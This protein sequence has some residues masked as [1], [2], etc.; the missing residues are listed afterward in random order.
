[1]A[2]KFHAM[3]P[4]DYAKLGSFVKSGAGGDSFVSLDSYSYGGMDLSDVEQTLAGMHKRQ[5]IRL[6]TPTFNYVLARSQ[7]SLLAKLLG[8]SHNTWKGIVAVDLIYDLDSNE[9]V[10]VDEAPQDG[11]YL[12]GAE[13]AERFISDL[14]VEEAKL[15]CI[16]GAIAD[17]MR[18]GA[19]VSSIFKINRESKGAH[20]TCDY[21][22]EYTKEDLEKYYKRGHDPERFL[23][24]FT[25]KLFAN[26]D[27]RF[28]YLMNMNQDKSGL[29]GMLNYYLSVVPEEMRP[30]IDRGEHKLTARYAKVLKADFEYKAIKGEH[31]NPKDI[32]AKYLVMDSSV[33]RLQ[34]KNV[35]LGLKSV[36]KDDLAI[37][38]RVKSKKGQVRLNNLGK[39]QDYSGRAVVVI[40]PYLPVDH[41]RVP[42]TML[43]KLYEYHLLPY[44]AKNIENNQK[45]RDT[46]SE[47]MKNIYDKIHLTNLNE[48]EAR[49]EMLRILEEEKI[50][51][52][53]PMYLGRQPTLHKQSLQGFHVEASD[54]NAIEVSP[55]VCPAFNMDFDGD[56]AHGEVPLSEEA[57][58]EVRDL[59]MTTQ[60]IFLAKNGE[61]TIEPRQDMLYG[62]YMCTQES[63]VVGAHPVS[64]IYE[65]YE[66]VRQHVMMHKVRVDAT[67]TVAKTGL[68]LLAGDAA[69]IACFAENDVVP[70]DVRPNQNQLAVK[71]ITSKTI[72]P[73]IEHILRTDSLGNFIYPLGTGYDKP[74]TF[75]G[76]INYLVELG[77][78][79]A[80]IY[81]PSMSLIRQNADRNTKTAIDRFH[82]DMESADFYYGMGLETSD[83]YQIEFDKQLKKLDDATDSSIFDML[84]AENGYVLLSKSGAR[85]SKN[86]LTQ[87]FA[88][89]GRV[90][91]NSSES[92]NALLVN[93][94]ADQMTPMEHFV[95]AYGG[96][97]GQIDKSL[98]TGDTGYAMRQMWH[99][100]QGL[101]ITSEDCGATQGLKVSKEF[102]VSLVDTPD[103]SGEE[104]AKAIKKEVS[105]IF[106]HALQGR[107]KVGSNRMITKSEAEAWAED[108]NID[109]VEIRSPLYCKNPCCR[110]C[111]GMD[112]SSHKLVLKGLPV[113]II[114]AQ[115]IGEPGSQLTLKQFQ[116]GG[117]SGKA[118]FTS[119]FDKVNS[120]IHVQNLAE[121]SKKGTY[122]GYDPLA[123]D[124]GEIKEEPSSDITMKVV[125]IGENKKKIVVPK[126]V[127]LKQTAV[128]GQ[129]LSY[130][131]GD[132]SIPEIISYCG[133]G[134]AQRYLA[135]KLFYLY[136]NEV[137]IE[138][139][140]F[141]VLATCM[142]RYMI[143]STD[144]KDLMVGQYCTSQEL[145]A[146]SI[147]NTEYQPR[148]LSVTDLIQASNEA[149]DSIIMENQ[150]HGLSR[151]CL[152]ELS[153]TLTK[154]INRMVMGQT[155]VN[156]S[157]TPGFIDARKERIH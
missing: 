53:I 116:K 12:Y 126:S 109:T 22:A 90:K 95:D 44:L 36:K 81:A 119:A 115:S 89:K 152:L 13:I 70:R 128:K 98:K 32:R 9:L 92:F 25:N 144:R 62:L 88:Y 96:R 108:D 142:T 6:S 30:K 68:T 123:W 87:A 54:L 20:L 153:D 31:A 58:R 37:L 61:C 147:A 41:I 11:R 75:V 137:K 56:Q 43:P 5:V 35:G 150:S 151:I 46:N 52:R 21:Y 125:T 101:S 132:Y 145:Y 133:I 86:N 94:Y 141:E 34:Y 7:A 120:Y 16:R 135:F 114:A 99:A 45:D 84:G 23:E 55:L 107:F 26:A 10:A 156:G 106:V 42:K 1:M 131:H 117:V 157:N 134:D 28:T 136:K 63:Y 110:R 91:K 104:A 67:V 102:L 69:F 79:V 93:S 33:S 71:Q 124:S 148:L 105:E 60:N 146:G 57:I 97:Q 29:Y 149:L 139:A 80:R 47:H 77:F 74:G 14:D 2:A 27:T 72:T 3:T 64:Y 51:D 138:M 19:P 130:K 121:L 24:E 118:E 85:G 59:L 73:Y 100:T 38:E 83:N 78:K 18:M 113:G 48:P 76:T 112:W 82:K 140:H 49:A 129:G 143:T 127:Q 111:Y 8:V 17:C 39:R 65:D 50:L 66:E 154:P 155:I 122:S 15:Q 103:S 4:E 40:N